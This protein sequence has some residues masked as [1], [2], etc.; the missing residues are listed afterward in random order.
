[1]IETNVMQITDRATARVKRHFTSLLCRTAGRG[2]CVSGRSC[3]RPTRK[4]VFLV[5]PFSC[6][7]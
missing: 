7:C 4:E 5:F 6:R 3:D 1:M 2:Q